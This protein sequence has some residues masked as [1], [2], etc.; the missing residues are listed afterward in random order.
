MIHRQDVA[1][2]MGPCT[3][4]DP[5]DEVDAPDPRASGTLMHGRATNREWQDFSPS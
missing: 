3:P 1:L 4:S 5:T 2:A